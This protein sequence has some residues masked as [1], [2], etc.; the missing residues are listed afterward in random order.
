M[1]GDPRVEADECGREVVEGLGQCTA[2][3]VAEAEATEMPKPG[4]CPLD[5]VPEAP[6]PGAVGVVLGTG[7]R[8]RDPALAGV[9]DSDLPAVSPVAQVGVWSEAWTF[10]PSSFLVRLP[11]AS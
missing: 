11:L 6:Q 3:L 7:Q 1:T 5:N 2:L 8:G 4:Q 9:E 10:V